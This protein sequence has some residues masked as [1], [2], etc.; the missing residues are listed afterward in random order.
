[1]HVNKRFLACCISPAVIYNSRRPKCVWPQTAVPP[2]L[3]VATSPV[4]VRLYLRNHPLSILSAAWPRL[5]CPLSLQAHNCT[6]HG[7]SPRGIFGSVNVLAIRGSWEKIKKLN[8]QVGLKHTSLNLTK[9]RVSHPAYFGGR[10][11]TTETRFNLRGKSRK[12][13]TIFFFSSHNTAGGERFGQMRPVA[14]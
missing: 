12:K 14:C 7:V 5:P 9:R 4:C 8:K 3:N 13:A 6:L 11:A 1:M 2:P 10:C